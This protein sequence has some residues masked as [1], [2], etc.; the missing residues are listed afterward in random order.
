MSAELN[1]LGG[2]SAKVALA[3]LREKTEEPGGREAPRWGPGRALSGSL[4]VMEERDGCSGGWR[5]EA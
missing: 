4:A 2:P 1:G 3:E 5:K